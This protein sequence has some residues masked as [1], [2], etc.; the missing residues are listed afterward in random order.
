MAATGLGAVAA[1]AVVAGPVRPGGSSL[2]PAAGGHPRVSA[3]GTVAAP[4]ASVPVTPTAG[5]HPTASGT[6]GPVV[7]PVGSSPS[8]TPSPAPATTTDPG[9]GA[10]GAM[11]RTSTAYAVGSVCQDHASSRT[12]NGWCLR[13]AGALAGNPGQPV[14]LAVEL[15]RLPGFAAGTASFPTAQEA[16]F[17]VARGTAPVW[18]WSAGR[19]FA[20]V[21]HGLTLDAGRCLRW[22][23]TWEVR[24]D[25]GRPLASGHYT[26][27]P[28]VLAD[29]LSAGSD[30]LRE[31]YD[32][33]VR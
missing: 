15:C 24:D 20:H 28:D 8:A 23:T 32:F 19:S 13:Y 21:R 9:S 6:V 26:L 17:G 33:T 29:N 22:T 7:P 5:V 25:A 2:D 3:T 16:E 18:R 11:T 4:S 27:T 12:A 31:T 10:S 30:Y 14:T 1:F